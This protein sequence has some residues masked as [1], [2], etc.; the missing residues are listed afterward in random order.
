MIDRPRSGAPLLL[1]LFLVVLG[2]LFLGQTLG[3]LPGGGEVVVG[4]LVA[5]AGLG[6]LATSL[7]RR[8]GWWAAIAGASAAGVGVLIVVEALWPT[9]TPSWSAAIVLLAVGVGFLVAYM[10]SSM[11]WWMLIPAGTLLTLA[12]VSALSSALPSEVTS[13]VFMFGMGLT[14]AAVAVAPWPPVKRRW[15]LIPAAVFGLLG[16]AALA[17]SRVGGVVWPIAIIAAGVY[18]LVRALRSGAASR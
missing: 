3:F 11:Q 14:F 9:G 7:A 5:G 17:T 10:L 8:L 6:L 16:V 12:A 18:L 4:L 13:A 2:V 15:A 1:G